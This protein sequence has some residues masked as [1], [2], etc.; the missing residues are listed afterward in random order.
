MTLRPLP[1]DSR[2]RWRRRDVPGREEARAERT[3]AGWRLTGE[4]EVEEASLAAQLRYAIEGE[5]DWRPR[6]AVVVGRGRA[7]AKPGSRSRRMVWTL[8]A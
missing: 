6:S 4:L 1:T 7:A 3:P 8:D 5:P 2:V